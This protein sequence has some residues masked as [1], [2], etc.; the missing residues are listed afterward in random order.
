MILL[1][2]DNRD[3]AEIVRRSLR[4]QGLAGDLHHVNDGRGALD[5]L[6]RRDEYKD[7][8]SSP[9]PRV[10][11]L[12]LRLPM[13]DGL[14]FLKEIKEHEELRRIPVVV[15]TSSEMEKD[16]VMAYDYHANSYLVKPL[17][18]E[19]FTNLI[20]DTGKYWLECNATVAEVR[21]PFNDTTQKEGRG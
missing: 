1:I 17:D 18:S 19:Q 11:F 15:L 10:I 14:E 7:P 9:R 2:E 6:L 20:R 16:L 21:L 12:D 4:S 5:Y 13:T 3:H 8:Q